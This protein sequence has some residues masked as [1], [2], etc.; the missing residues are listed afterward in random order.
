MLLISCKYTTVSRLFCTHLVVL[1]TG[2]SG[3]Q[4]IL[5][6]CV[7]NLE[8]QALPY[9]HIVHNKTQRDLLASPFNKAEFVV[10]DGPKEM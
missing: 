1:A 5:T 10:R 3:R 7:P 2:Q 9:F 6:I 8:Q 4:A